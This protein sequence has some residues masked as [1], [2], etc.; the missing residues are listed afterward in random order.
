MKSWYK[1]KLTKQ[2]KEAKTLVI[3]ICKALSKAAGRGFHVEMNAWNNIYEGH[4]I[5]EGKC[6]LNELDAYELSADGDDIGMVFFG[7]HFSRKTHK[8]ALSRAWVSLLEDC[9]GQSEVSEFH[10]LAECLKTF[11]PC[12]DFSCKSAAELDKLLLKLDC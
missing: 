12:L 6:K 7:G 2:G 11:G 10:S 5:D 8:D 9:I 1:K 4:I 3:R